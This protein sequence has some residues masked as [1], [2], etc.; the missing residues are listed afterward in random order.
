MLNL[1]ESLESRSRQHPDATAL[2]APGRPS[3][4]YAGLEERIRAIVTDLRSAGIGAQDR[5]AIIVPN[6]ADLAVTFLAVTT[7]AVAAPLNPNYR[8]EE[9][10]FYIDD[11]D[12]KALIIQAD[13][14]EQAHKVARTRG[15]TIFELHRKPNAAAGT[16]DLKIA[17]AGDI[18]ADPLPL[19]FLSLDDFALILHTSGTTSR[20]K[21]VPLKQ[22]NLC[23]SARNIGMTLA[24]T[25]AD[26]CL[27]VMP[28]FHIH[29]LVGAL[30]SSITA[31][32]SVVCTPGFQ[33]PSFFAYLEEFDPTW[34][35]AV[36]TMHQAILSRSAS[37]TDTISRSS[38][39]LIRSSSAALAPQVLAELEAIFDVPVV[40]SYGMTEAA[41]QMAS[42]PL[43]PRKRKPGSVGMA[44]GPDVAIMDESGRLLSSGH[45]GEIVIRGAT[46]IDAYENNPKANTES[47]TDGW[48]RTGDQGYLDNEGYLF[49]T[50]RLKEIIN[51]GGEKISPREIDEVLLGH[52]DVMQVVTFAVPDSQLGEEIGAAV[53]LAADASISD[54]DIQTF[55]ATHLVDFKVPR[56]IVVLDEI[57]KGPTGKLQRIGLAEKL[58]LSGT[59]S[60]PAPVYRAP[61]TPIE[62]GIAD[63]WQSVLAVEKVGIDDDFFQHLGGDSILVT[64][65]ITRIRDELNIELS[66]VDFFTTPTVAAIADPARTTQQGGDMLPAIEPAPRTERAELSFSQL[67]MWLLDQMDPGCSAYNRPSAMRLEGQLNVAALE[68]SLNEVVRRHDAVRTRFAADNGGVYQVITSVLRLKLYIADITTSR[69]GDD[70]AGRAGALAVNEVQRSFDLAADPLIR[71]GLLR[72]GGRRHILLLTFHHSIFDDWSMGV[73]LKE[74]ESHY[75]AFT[76]GGP[77]SL[78]ELPIQYADFSRWQRRLF[79]ESR[80]DAEIR[81]WREHLSDVKTLNLPTDRPRPAAQSHQGRQ[82]EVL[83]SPELCAA[84]KQLSRQENVTLFM[85]LAGVFQ[86]LLYRYSGQEDIVI[87]APVAGRQHIDTESLIGIFIN[88]FILRADLS[89]S[90]SFSTFLQRVRDTA[91]KAYAHQ[92]LPF[93]KLVELLQPGRDSSRNPI[94]QVMFQLRNVPSHVVEVGDLEIERFRFDPHTALLD[95]ALDVLE[96]SDGLSCVFRFN[97]ALFE[98]DTIRQMAGHYHALL[99]QVVSTPSQQIAKFQLAIVSADQTTRRCQIRLGDD[100]AVFEKREES[101]PH[102]FRLQVE[103]YPQRLAVQTGRHKW[104]YR[105]LNQRASQIA[106]LMAEHCTGVSVALLLDHDAPMVAAILGAMM[107][108]KMYVPLSKD[109]PV[110]RLIYILSDSETDV[111]LVD[112]AAGPPAMSLAQATPKHQFRIIPIE[113]EAS[114]ADLER[115][116]VPTGDSLAYLLYTSGSTGRPKGI[117]QN[118]RN[119]L[120]FARAY[121]NALNITCDD[122]L[123]LIPPCIWDGSVADILSALL[124]GAALY[125]VD[126]KAHDLDDLSSWL[127]DAKITIYHSTPTIF[128]R[129]I[130]TITH[131]Q[132][133]DIRLVVLGGEPVYRH[134]LENFRKVFTNSCVFVND[135]GASESSISLQNIVDK[136]ARM[137]RHMLAAGR[138]FDDTEVLLC[139]RAGDDGQVFGEIVVC[140]PYLALEYWKQPELTADVFLPDTGGRRRYRTGDLGR[141]LPD[142]TIECLGR[143]DTQVKLHGIRIEL[144]EIEAV[145]NEHPAVSQSAVAVTNGDPRLARL[146]AYV[147]LHDASGDPTT[148]LR[149][150]MVQKLPRYMVPSIFMRLDALPQTA[151][152]KTQRNAL[153]EPSLPAGDVVAP[154]TSV[155]QDLVEIWSKLFAGRSVGITDDFFEFGGHS[156][157]A[158]RLISRILHKFQIAVPMRTVFESPTIYALARRIESMV[159]EADEKTDEAYGFETGT[160]S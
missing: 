156:L 109:D 73:L 121:S 112:D 84:L 22:R 42:N 40:E 123:T 99:E 35:T 86:V 46:V 79:D 145:L 129:W 44:A 80:L 111:V 20:P 158:I 152:G 6:G 27:N 136:Q 43:P 30:L 51:R 85:T 88:T 76:V 147:V 41:H 59:A 151:S 50:G 153:P 132:F 53:V 127:I 97:T 26:R 126:L 81:Y 95:L 8:S 15:I 135:Y 105:E 131:E 36:P 60:I 137:T 70:V 12:A 68:Q 119:A 67:R 92:A 10:D 18:A 101:I 90:P 122:R 62:S 138:P 94:F 140:S 142:G 98:E 3:L 13:F 110:E 144:E 100:A 91:L 139:N 150:Y 54:R 32:A 149:P 124:N 114:D 45:T 14:A 134:D 66:V 74:L 157:L 33:A 64:R 75:A 31:G 38:L 89:G 108:G 17:S 82:H 47:F 65:A 19:D 63:I 96:R 39:R 104:T 72:L 120:H 148:V 116:P 117:I 58:G 37:H 106:A 130:D 102:R 23:G 1:I 61:R 83:V 56:R 24:L 48:F 9:F 115:L 87:G 125:P 78:P 128:R 141:M 57:P 103:K 118:Q 34:Y 155:E 69:S 159:L 25:K 7:C 71:A 16:F 107:A 29:G 133:P 49:I 5:V 154:T 55:A 143:A 93:D 146:V 77:S 113:Q 2:V 4:T 11:V 52:P 21:R 160:I 28:L